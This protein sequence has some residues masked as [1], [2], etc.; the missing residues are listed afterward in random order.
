GE[1]QQETLGGRSVTGELAHHV[2]VEHALVGG[3]LV[4]DADRLAGLE[5]DVGIEELEDRSLETGAG[6]LGRLEQF[7]WHS[8]RENAPKIRPDSRRLTPDSQR[9][10]RFQGRQRCSHSFLNYFFDKE[11]VAKARLELRRMDVH[12][13]GV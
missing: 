1:R 4:D 9:R 2:F 5:R 11:L 3:M 7:E 6:S 10:S 13:H 8:C 12:V